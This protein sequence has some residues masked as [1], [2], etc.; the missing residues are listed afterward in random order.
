MP[1][2]CSIAKTVVAFRVAPLSPCSTGRTGS[3]T[4][5]AYQFYTDTWTPRHRY[6]FD[7]ANIDLALPESRVL[8]AYDDW[9]E[10]L[11][12]SK[13]KSNVARRDVY[14]LRRTLGIAA[15]MFCTIAALPTC[16][17]MRDPR[18]LSLMCSVLSLHAFHIQY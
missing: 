16:L 5:S 2:Q 12:L 6:G 18:P 14:S 7:N 1:S 9:A 11:T 4:K 15:L 3:W 13:A 17:Y 10:N 8:K